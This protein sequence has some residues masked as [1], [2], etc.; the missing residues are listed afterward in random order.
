MFALAACG[1]SGNAPIGFSNDGGP[2]GP[3]GKD[4]GPSPFGGD[5]GSPVLGGD[6]STLPDGAVP[7]CNPSSPDEN[8]CHCQAGQTH[9]CYTGNPL[10]RGVGA[11]KDGTQT[12]MVTGEQGNFGPCTGEVLPV[13][14]TGHCSSTIDTNCDGKVGCADPDCAND[15]ACMMM[16]PPPPPPDAGSVCVPPMT[17]SFGGLRCPDGTVYNIL[18]NMCCPC[19][20]LD[21]GTNQSC[22]AASVCAGDPS[23][24]SCSGMPLDPICNGLVDQD[25]D[26]FPED[27]DQ[28]CCPCKPAGTCMVC[29]SGFVPCDD[30]FGN[31]VCTDVSS[32][33]QQC[34]ACDYACVG[35]Q[36]CVK[37]WC[38]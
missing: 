7:N 34:G 27:C 19:T 33:P 15:P 21:C 12:C 35:T 37:G 26:D 13:P 5:T 9:A 1:G 32:N 25:C 36:Q 8:G 24:A 38:Q 4:G 6:A 18:T 10:T 14:E 23:C 2:G 11:C 22:C 28:L 17:S 30:G 3:P 31:L 16:P 20:S 29:Q